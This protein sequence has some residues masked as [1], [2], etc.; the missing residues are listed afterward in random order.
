MLAIPPYKQLIIHSAKVNGLV[1][2]FRPPVAA[3]CPST[4]AAQ[5]ASE[6][7]IESST[8]V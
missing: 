5:T 6:L 8:G 1:D 7:V 2:V 4:D 3:L